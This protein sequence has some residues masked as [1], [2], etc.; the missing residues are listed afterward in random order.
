MSSLKRS[1]RHEKIYQDAIARV[2]FLNWNGISV[3]ECRW[4]S[5]T[6][7][8]F[9]IEVNARFWGSLHLPIHAGV[10]F[11][12]LLISAWNN[13]LFPIPEAKIGACCQL[14]FPK[15]IEYVFSR[16]RASSLGAREKIWT[17]LE[18]AMLSI[19]TRVK[20]DMFFPGDSK[21]YRRS[22]SDSVRK[23]LSSAKFYHK[24]EGHDKKNGFNRKVEAVLVRPK[25]ASCLFRNR[26]WFFG[27]FHEIVVPFTVNHHMSS[28][29]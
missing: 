20:S 19:D 12:K 1:W 25:D 9:L 8:F 13:E 2:N 3:F 15:E 7:D 17:L 18:F 26:S 22:I 11:P 28:C 21:L 10:D 29:T 6:D 16:M 4:D 23:F 27:L 5:S 24:Y 14:I